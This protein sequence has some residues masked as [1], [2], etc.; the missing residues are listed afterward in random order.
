MIFFRNQISTISSHDHHN[1]I[2]CIIN[3]KIRS[4][5]I[6]FALILTPIQL[7]IRFIKVIN[8]YLLPLLLKIIDLLLQLHSGL[9]LLCTLLIDQGMVLLFVPEVEVVV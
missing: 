9:F 4:N 1:T 2:R 3:E 5:F 6:D 8:F 7:R